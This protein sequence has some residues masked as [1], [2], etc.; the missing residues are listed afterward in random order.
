MKLV[1]LHG[2]PATGKLTVA[3][4]LLRIVPGRLMDNHAAIDFAR[5]I[6]DFGAPGFWELVHS[7]RYSAID[8]A[9]GNGVSLLVTTFCYVEPDDRVQYDQF[10]AIMQRHGGELLPVFLLCSREEAVRRIGNPDRVER[11]KMT[12]GESLGEFLD[13]YDLSPVPRPDCLKLDTGIRPADSTA[14]EIVRHFGLNV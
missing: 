8:A 9:A 13:S 12:S 10:E 3:K 2:A 5:T 6:F 4:A 7:V 1:F 11:R 14:R